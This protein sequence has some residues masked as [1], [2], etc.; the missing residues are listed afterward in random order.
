MLRSP[1]IYKMSQQVIVCFQ[2]KGWQPQD[3]G[4]ADVSVWVQRQKK[5]K[6]EEEEEE[7]AKVL[8]QAEG[9]FFYTEK[10]QQF[11]SIQAFNW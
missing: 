1:Q 7:E 8:F 5:K 10:D 2:F 9:I 11:C 3:P 6:K 4:S